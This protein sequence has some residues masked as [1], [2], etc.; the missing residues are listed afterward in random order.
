MNT[1]TH[2]VVGLLTAM[3]LA[4]GLFAY[5]RGG[6]RAAITLVPKLLFLLGATQVALTG[7]ANLFPGV[8][9][10]TGVA[11]TAALGVTIVS[12]VD[13]VTSPL[14]ASLRVAVH[15]VLVAAVM[16]MILAPSW[17]SANLAAR[18]PLA[19]G[20]VAAWTAVVVVIIQCDWPEMWC[21]CVQKY[22]R[23][24]RWP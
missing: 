13:V 21:R 8:P 6:L 18:M 20:T 1:S 10:T 11:W 23:L 14:R 7:L 5:R 3:S 17:G 4:T 9:E 15:A 22:P 19:A 24:G 12:L 2:E 16:V